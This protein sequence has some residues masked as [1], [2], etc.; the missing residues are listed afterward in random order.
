RRA[1]PGGVRA[2]GRALPD[3][4][5]AY[6][7]AADFVTT[8]ARAASV[9]SFSNSAAVIFSPGPTGRVA[10]SA[11]TQRPHSA[12]VRE[13]APTKS[14]SESGAVPPDRM[15]C[16]TSLNSRSRAFTERR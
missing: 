14:L 10:R 9:F 1:R 8:A 11:R 4:L 7:A 12:T 13:M 5:K 2:T 6:G 3:V 15:E 16:R